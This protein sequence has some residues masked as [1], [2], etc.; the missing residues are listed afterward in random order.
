MKPG[1]SYGSGSATS[2]LSSGQT[3]P[4]TALGDRGHRE[5]RCGLKRCRGVP[6]MSGWS[7]AGVLRTSTS[8]D[9]RPSAV[10]L[11]ARRIAEV[12]RGRAVDVDERGR[13]TKIHRQGRSPLGGGS[14]RPARG[15][16]VAWR[17]CGFLP[18]NREVDRLPLPLRTSAPAFRLQAGYRAR[19]SRGSRSCQTPRARCDRGRTARRNTRGCDALSLEVGQAKHR[20]GCGRTGCHLGQI[21]TPAGIAV[22]ATA[23]SVSREIGTSG[24]RGRRQSRMPRI[25]P[26]TTR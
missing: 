9:V 25:T 3:L 13:P 8:P 12:R 7:T 10:C 26:N 2:M 6:R 24:T 20:R 22:A 17:G 14:P 1:R 15:V 16:V 19:G 4:D 18:R 21:A 5:G 23:S 11:S